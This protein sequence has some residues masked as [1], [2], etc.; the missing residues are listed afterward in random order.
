MKKIMAVFLIA[1][2]GVFSGGR[3]N[4]GVNAGSLSLED[5]G[6]KAAGPV[7]D[8]KEK[9][10]G[11]QAITAEQAILLEKIQRIVN[12]KMNQ[13]RK[14]CKDVENFIKPTENFSTEN[15]SKLH[16]NFSLACSFFSDAAYVKKDG[17]IYHATPEGQQVLQILS[18]PRR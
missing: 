18:E 5:A 12:S 17:N 15:F 11:M 7:E 13:A 3:V 16:D 2:L 10:K 14:N 4:A 8:F 9:M 6:G 1:G